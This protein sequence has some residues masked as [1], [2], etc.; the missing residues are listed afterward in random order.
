[1]AGWYIDE[2]AQ[3]HI[4]RVVKVTELE[5]TLNK[6]RKA[7]MVAEAKAEGATKEELEIIKLIADLTKKRIR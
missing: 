2:K 7:K 1:M 6:K 3:K 5:R 4:D